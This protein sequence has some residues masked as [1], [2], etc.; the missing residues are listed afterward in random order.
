MRTKH[1]LLGNIDFVGE[2]YKKDLISNVILD[3]IF[4]S[5]LG[6]NSHSK[7]V[8]DMTIDAALNLINKLGAKIEDREHQ[9]KKEETKQVYRDSNKMIFDAFR[10]L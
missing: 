7:Q 6:I 3:S 8:N 1:K 9:S 4:E 10:A 2:L 5:L